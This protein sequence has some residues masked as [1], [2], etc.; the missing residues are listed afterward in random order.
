MA[1][2]SISWERV[3]EA[4]SKLTTPLHPD[5]YL[6]RVGESARILFGRQHRHRIDQVLKAFLANQPPGREHQR[7]VDAD[8]GDVLP[9]L[10]P[11][12]LDETGNLADER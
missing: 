11:G 7:S 3:R 2:G 1:A 10:A 9:E 4:G 12:V 5:D 8:A 6:R